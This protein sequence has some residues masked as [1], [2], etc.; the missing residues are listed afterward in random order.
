[1]S[2]VAELLLAQ[3]QNLARVRE[4]RG[5]QWG[6]LIGNLAAIPGNIYAQRREQQQI[7]YARARQQ[8]QDARLTAQ[9][10]RQ[11]AA[12]AREDR[13]REEEARKK[14]IAHE[15]IK[16]Y[17]GGTP[18]DPT[19][20]NLEAGIAK[21][22]ALNAPEFI[23]GLVKRH[24][25]ETKLT[26]VDPTMDYQDASGRIVRKGTPKP[27]SW[28]TND[29]ALVAVGANP[30]SAAM[31][32]GALAAARPPKVETPG[33][34][35]DTANGLVRINPDN[36][37][38]PLGVQGYHPPAT[39][40]GGPGGTGLLT[41]EGE[42]FAGTQY[43]ITGKMPALG[44]SNS[45]ARAAIISEAA[46]QAKALRQTPAAAIQ[47]QSAYTSDRKALDRMT[48]M[49][50]SAEA[51][52]NKAVAQADI[53]VDLSK[54]VGRSQ[55]PL[56]NAA[57]LAGKKEILGDPQTQ[58][59]FNA[60]TTFTSE[61]AKIMEGSTGSVSASSDSARAASAKLVKASLNPAQLA[62][63]VDLMKREMRL[64]IQGYDATIAHI[65]ERMG[66]QPQAATGRIRV[67]GPNGETGTVPEGSVLPPGWTKQP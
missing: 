34:V 12:D 33:P 52:E 18:N 65:T 39:G 25:E 26:P 23:E 15:I 17:T 1:M 64:T 55:I 44:M 27:K 37:T 31:A 16:A 49:S 8:Q 66:G 41:P 21:A 30:V 46:A 57:L 38:T 6:A 20:N 5:Q 32:R 50:S 24:N 58:L 40:A 59:L 29:L 10:A 9:D 56:I 35:H 67:R 47:K 4:A 48:T 28:T 51:F 61:Y 53:V 63:T 3:G 36:T 62:Q 22:R 7:D 11:T 42:E 43:R 60:I 14:L 2:R 19:T 45:E 54:K 13:E